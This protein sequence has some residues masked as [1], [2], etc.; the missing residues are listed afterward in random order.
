MPIKMEGGGD[1]WKTLV[2]E[3]K[4]LC[5]KGLL[6]QIL[7][8]QQGT[9]INHLQTRFSFIVH[10]CLTLHIKT[11]F[12]IRQFGSREQ[13]ENMRRW[14]WLLIREQLGRA[15]FTT[16]KLKR[17]QHML[18]C[19]LDLFLLCLISAF[20]YPYMAANVWSACLEERDSKGDYCILPTCSDTSS[21]FFCYCF[22]FYKRNIYCTHTSFTH[23]WGNEKH[24]CKTHMIVKHKT[25][26]LLLHCPDQSWTANTR[27]IRPSSG[28]WDTLN[29]FK[30]S[31]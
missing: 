11:W 9:V 24:D 15:A 21:F 3:K 16:A 7:S 28:L 10:Y 4:Q 20:S 2:H 13:K 12:K 22:Q 25:H 26:C 31:H 23:S 5:I 30:I 19:R 8:E 6:H 1:F 27:L 17:N 29:P 14:F 18:L